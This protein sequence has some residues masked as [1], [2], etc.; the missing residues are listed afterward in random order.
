[1]A[2]P[3]AVVTGASSG[4]GAATA[5]ALAGDGWHVVLVARTKPRLEVVHQS[6][7]A[8][9]GTAVIETLDAADGEQVLAMADRVRL[10]LGRP[11]LVVNS[12]GM[13]A[14]KF[15]EDTPPEEARDMLGAPFLAAYNM[16]FAFMAD[17]IGARRG[18]LI[19]VG[20]PASKLP[21]PGATAYTTSRW[22]LRG[23]SEA[24]NQDLVGTG[25]TSSHV[26]FGEVS[27]PYFDHNQ[28]SRDHLPK[29][30]RLIP[31]TTPERCAEVILNTV[32]R[33]R[34][35]VAYPFM[36][37]AFYWMA[38]VAPG[39]TRWLVARSGRRH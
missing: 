18:T 30:A 35:E 29:L 16:S 37:R 28:V 12:A 1:M 36:L 13:G 17:M 24:L 26:V 34:R 31:V 25:V 27:S 9:G 3:L 32:R 39:P 23:L 4:I 19:H 7:T 38:A 5:R 8:G 15:I 6:I 11:D 21:W 14:W 20:S 22:A 10:E 33:P 2:A